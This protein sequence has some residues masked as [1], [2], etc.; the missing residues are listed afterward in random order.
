VVKPAAGRQPAAVAALGDA[1]LTAYRAVRK[2]MPLLCPGTACVAIGAGGRV[3]IGVQCLQATTA[4]RRVAA[5]PSEKARAPA[6]ELRAP[7]VFGDTS[8]WHYSAR[9]VLDF[10]GEQSADRPNLTSHQVEW[11]VAS[12][13]GP[14]WTV[15][16]SIGRGPR[17]RTPV[18]DHI[19]A[20]S[21]SGD[22]EWWVQPKLG[23]VPATARGI[24]GA[25]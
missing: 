24:G 11:L 13:A 18:S 7:E 3:H 17:G 14:E 23:R 16:C 6:T 21:K 20:T 12:A 19:P 4:T 9:V 25:R 5:D 1:R 10:V 8:Q 22:I 2:A 15:S